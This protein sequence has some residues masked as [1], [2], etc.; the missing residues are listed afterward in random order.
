MSQMAGLEKHKS[1]VNS[2][3]YKYL[4]SLN[5]LKNI[6]FLFLGQSEGRRYRAGKRQ[7]GG[8]SKPEPAAGLVPRALLPS[9]CLQPRMFVRP[10]WEQLPGVTCWV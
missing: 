10:D 7:G 3:K 1:N 8:R 9:E 6:S 4:V 5:F 2:S